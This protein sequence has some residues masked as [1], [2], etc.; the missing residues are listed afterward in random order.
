[1]KFNIIAVLPLVNIGLNATAETHSNIDQNTIE[2][3][4]YQQLFNHN[5]ELNSYDSAC[6]FGTNE[7]YCTSN[8][9]SS[10]FGGSVKSVWEITTDNQYNGEL[11]AGNE[12]ELCLWYSAGH[13]VGR[14]AT[15][16]PYGR[17]QNKS[18]VYGSIV[19]VDGYKTLSLTLSIPYLRPQTFYFAGNNIDNLKGYWNDQWHQ[20]DAK[21]RFVSLDIDTVSHCDDV[22]KF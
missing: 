4:V 21:I 1:M 9:W 7:S 18:N 3:E 17:N 8:S 10:G 16:N 19:D 5:S 11:S 13:F 6:T 20:G 15:D 2:N 22:F 12:Q 14:Y